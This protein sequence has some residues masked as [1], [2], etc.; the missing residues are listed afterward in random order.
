MRAVT[1]AARWFARASGSISGW[2]CLPY[3]RASPALSAFAAPGGLAPA[4]AGK[5]S[6][7]LLVT[8]VTPAARVQTPF[9]VREA[10]RS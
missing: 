2:D 10:G 9:R 7:Q 5:Q 1:D 3:D 8:T 4:A 6:S